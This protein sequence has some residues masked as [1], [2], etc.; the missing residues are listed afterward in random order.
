VAQEHGKRKQLVV[1]LV[2]LVLG[3]LPAFLLWRKLGGQAEVAATANQLARPLAVFVVWS[4]C[5]LWIFLKGKLKV[6][7]KTWVSVGLMAILV[8]A[9]FDRSQAEDI[10]ARL[11]AISVPWMI[12]AFAVQLVGMSGTVWRWK[13]LLEAQDL[14]VPLRHLIGTFLIGRFV[15]SFTPSTLGLDGYR[16]WDIAHHSGQ[17]ARSVSVIVVEKIIG[18]FV[19]ST[20]VVGTIPWG[21]RFIP[22]MALGATAVV[23]AV[24]VTLSFV[25]LL[26]P[27]LIR[28][29]ISRVLPPDTALG[30]K[31]GRAVKAVTAY[32]QNRRAL[33][34]AVGIGFIVHLATCVMY[35]F[36]A[37]AVGVDVGIGE[38]LY[39]GPLMITAVVV[40]ISVAGIGVRELVLS[41]VMSQAGHAAGA[42]VVF[43]FLGYLVGEVISLFGGLVLLARR[44]E[45]RV[46]ISGKAMEQRDTEKD[47][48]PEPLPVP[49]EQ[50]PRLV[51]YLLTGFGGG[52]AAG[53]LLGVAEA[54]V[55][56]VQ[57]QPPREYFVLGWAAVASG[58]TWAL[59]GAGLAL[60][61]W[62]GARALG[63]RAAP[64]ERRYAFVATTLFCG[65][66]FFVSWFRIARDIFD[67]AVRPRD[68][69]G[70]LTL[71]AL[72]AIYGV[73]FLLMGRA[74]RALAG[75][76]PGRFLLRPW[77]TP[78]AACAAAVVLVV[79]GQVLGEDHAHANG[80]SHG[81]ASGRPN[82]VLVMVDTVRADHLDLYGYEDETAPNL[83]S[84]A[85][86][87][88][89]F[90]NAFAQSS[91][92][93]PSVATILTGRFPSSHRAV[94]KPD[95]LPDEVE[96]VAEVLR[97]TGYRT[98]GVV[99]NY[100]LAPYF[101]FQQ[102]FDTYHYLEPDR[103]L[104]AD[105]ASAKLT[106]YELFRLIAVRVPR[107]L[108]PEQFYQDAE[109]ATDRT[110]E[111]LATTPSDEAPYFLFVSYM[112]PHDP[113]FRHP[114]DGHA[115]GRAIHGNPRPDQVEE[116]TEL[117]DGEIRYWD[118]HFG[119]LVQTLRRRPDWDR[120]IV[121]VCSD[122]GE[123][124]YDHGGW[125]HGITLY[126]EQV[127]VPLVVRLPS[128]ELG[129]TSEQRWVG[130]VDIAPTI[131][132]LV[133]ADVPEGMRQGVDL[134]DAGGTERVMFAEEDHEGNRLRSVRYRQGD[135]EWKLIE[136][137]ADNRRGLEPR[138]L[139]ELRSDPAEAQ[140]RTG[141]AEAGRASEHLRQ[142][143]DDAAV[144]AVESTSVGLDA[145]AVERLRAIGYM[146]DEDQR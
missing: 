129:G 88:V 47:D 98:G 101:N 105:D 80:S 115:I 16:M 4:A 134:F 123:E 140:S 21:L 127:R 144:G 139:Y 1:R 53:L 106:I 119:R 30:A 23:F 58:L 31:V 112:D 14:K 109:A 73:L 79:A 40:P 97:S 132:R 86:D 74:L 114:Y 145:A 72:A 77:G 93:R 49:A 62:A 65:F 59:A 138:E 118:E 50:R 38:V 46:V 3:A 95:A 36:T 37:H 29:V 55:V 41:Q 96:T 117:Y 45:Y 68:P 66:G 13:V 32:E 42:A 94:T 43:A 131:A 7:A 11:A 35:F 125:Y 56:L 10:V 111:W 69:M 26:Q 142:A 103:M 70:M 8:W 116:V 128:S 71:V 146:E 6:L 76:R 90:R 126:E 108:R 61:S 15:G 84:F 57:M 104:L 24:P 110:I 27:R 28:R 63:L 64:R 2:W 52:M 48:I 17:T 89:T 78:A 120:T 82:V 19:L 102:G 136:A 75:S 133:G 135:E 51:E 34:K 143:A 81:S 92:T 87:A 99:T 44:H 39:A 25:L 100:N 5:G 20:L 54:A 83:T 130:L 141:E 33:I 91:W 18:F 67:E 12:G 60:T 9:V 22:P 85:R 137:N 107:P 124:L 122:H 121:I 113:Y